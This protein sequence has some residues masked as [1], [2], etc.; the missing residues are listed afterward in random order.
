MTPFAA[1]A[2][3]RHFKKSGELDNNQMKLLNDLQNYIKSNFPKR[4]SGIQLSIGD[5]F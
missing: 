1:L 3:I 4:K 2:E 5:K